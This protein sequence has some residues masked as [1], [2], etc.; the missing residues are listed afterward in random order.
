MAKVR[1]SGM[2][3]REQWESFFDPGAILEALGCKGLSG[4]ILEMGCGYGT[5]TVEAAHRTSATVY[6]LDIEPVMV[7]A[8]ATRIS[9]AGYRNVVVEQRDFVTDGCGRPDSSIS[10]V[11]MFN[12]LH[13]E[14][15]VGL[16]RE[17]YRVLRPG[18]SVGVIHW[19]REAETP[20]GPPLDIRPR[21]EEC[22]IWA[23][24]ANLDPVQLEEL[25]RSPWHWGMLLTRSMTR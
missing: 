6:A 25:P 7:A 11:L 2:P 24:R 17:A 23:Q 15:P 19:I 9:S 18:G 21:P 1:D 8:T 5:F 3:P 4:D 20:R 22:R 10:F 12:I 14:D 13:L 16:L